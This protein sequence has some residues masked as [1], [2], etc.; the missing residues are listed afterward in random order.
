MTKYWAN[1]HVFY[2]SAD[3]NNRPLTTVFLKN[4]V[5]P[6]GSYLSIEGFNHLNVRGIH[7]WFPFWSKNYRLTRYL[8]LKSGCHFLTVKYI[9]SDEETRSIE[10]FHVTSMADPLPRKKWPFRMGRFQKQL[11]L[12]LR[13]HFKVF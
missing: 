11:F 2:H 10:P 13:G 7:F 6:V 8:H 12:S 9:V 5:Y 1:V 3:V 4:R